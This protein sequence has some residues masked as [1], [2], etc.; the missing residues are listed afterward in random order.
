ML[1]PD[2][3]DILGS[4]PHL[5]TLRLHH[6]SSQFTYPSTL[7]EHSFPALRKLVLAFLDMGYVRDIWRIVPLVSRLESVS[8]DLARDQIGRS[9]QDQVD[10]LHLSLPTMCFLSPNIQ[11]LTIDFATSASISPRAIL[12]ETLD[13]LSSLS[14]R[15][16]I[17]RGV[18]CHDVSS[19]CEILASFSA[20]RDLRLPDL[21]LAYKDLP[22]FA[23]IPALK[24]LEANIALHYF[25]S[26][27]D[28]PTPIPTSASTL[29]FLGSRARPL[30]MLNQTQTKEVAMWVLTLSL[31]YCTSHCFV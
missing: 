8:I 17:L 25:A 13:L 1:D 4:L 3:L 5:E 9:D 31:T 11:E 12:V 7:S 28:C 14:L 6:E 18:T 29:R 21:V 19:A 30:D 15:K 2:A 22:S 20:L 23:R 27:S 26:I 24:R 10:M 16:L